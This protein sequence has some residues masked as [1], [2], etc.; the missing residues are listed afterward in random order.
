MV[1]TV[2]VRRYQKDDTVLLISERDDQP[3]LENIAAVSMTRRER[4]RVALRLLFPRKY[5]SKLPIM[6][7]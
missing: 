1:D 5:T 4:L 3:G 2:Q 7:G 6:E